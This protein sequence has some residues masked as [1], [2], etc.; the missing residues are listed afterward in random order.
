MTKKE[1]EEHAETFFTYTYTEIEILDELARL[2]CKRQKYFEKMSMC[3][4][5]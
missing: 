5:K 3:S 2:S 1:C 4:E